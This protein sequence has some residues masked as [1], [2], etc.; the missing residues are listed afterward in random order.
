M[1]ATRTAA[2]RLGS[3]D[4]TAGSDDR[5]CGSRACKGDRNDGEIGSL[6]RDSERGIAQLGVQLEL[7]E[8]HSSADG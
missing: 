5:R 4:D 7:L 3:P 2:N 1:F 6:Q 8:A